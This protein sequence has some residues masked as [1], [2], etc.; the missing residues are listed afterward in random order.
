MGAVYLAQD[1]TLGRNVAIKVVST[2]IAGDAQSKLRFIREARTLA[3]IE[4]PHVV[5]V[6]EFGE[7]GG[8]AYLVME[9][10]EGETLA[11]RLAVGGPLP[12]YEALRIMRQVM[13]ALE[14]AWERRVIHRDIK[15][16][17]ILIDRRG[18][19]RVADFGLA[20]PLDLPEGD[21]SLTQ[22]GFLLGTPDYV[23]PEQAQGKEIDF[24]SDIYSA[25][26]ALYQMLVGSTPFEG[27]TQIAVISKHLQEPVPSIR[28]RRADVSYELEKLVMWMTAKEPGERPASH[29]KLM[30]A[31]DALLP[32]APISPP[33]SIPTVPLAGGARRPGLLGRDIQTMS[34]SARVALVAASSAL[35]IAIGWVST[36]LSARRRPPPLDVAHV[37]TRPLAVAVTPFYGPDEDS[38]KEGRVMASLI[39]DAIVQRLGEADARVF[40]I[41]ETKSPVRGHEQA[42][43]LAGRLDANAV[44]WGEAFAVRGETEIQPRVTIMRSEPSMNAARR[45]YEPFLPLDQ[46][47]SPTARFLAEAPNQIELRRTSAAGIADLVL[48]IAAAHALTTQGA[49]DRALDYL[50]QAPR[51]AENLRL[52]AQALAQLNRHDDAYA[53]VEE[54]IKLDRNSA[55]TYALLGDLYLAANRF[56]EAAGAYGKAEQ[57]GRPYTSN[58]GF[59]Q[60]G[61]LYLREIYRSARY[62][63]GTEQGTIYLLAVDPQT[64]HV[65][66]RYALPGPPLSFRRDGDSIEITYGLWSSVGDDWQEGQ[67]TVMFIK[68]EFDRPLW[69]PPWFRARIESKQSGYAIAANFIASLVSWRSWEDD[70][71]AKFELAGRVSEDVPS[72]LPDLETAL[73]AAADR[74]PTQPWYLFLLTLTLDAEGQKVDAHAMLDEMLRNDYP[75]TP[76]YEFT[77]MMAILERMR[78]YDWCDS[79]FPKAL[80][81]RSRIPQ[82][83]G[84]AGWG[85]SAWSAPFAREAAMNRDMD[86]AWIALDRAR[87][88]GG[89]RVDG[90]AQAAAAWKLYFMEHGDS[91][92]ADHEKLILNAMRDLPLS[93]AQIGT[94]VD[95]ALSLAIAS[96]FSFLSLAGVVVARAAAR[97]DR[98]SH[99]STSPPHLQVRSID[100]VASA[101]GVALAG[102]GGSAIVIGGVWLLVALWES[103]FNAVD[104]SAVSLLGA[105][106]VLRMLLR[107]R[108]RESRV[109]AV[110]ALLACV[111][112]STAYLFSLA[113]EWANVFRESP[114][115]IVVFLVIAG[116]FRGRPLSPTGI[117]S[118]L[119]PRERLAMALS[120]APFLASMIV[121]VLAFLHLETAGSVPIIGD[122]L[123]HETIVSDLE[124]RLARKPGSKP[125]VYVTAVANHLA[126]NRAR[127]ETLYAQLSDDPRAR[128]NAAALTKGSMPVNP[129]TPEDISRAYASTGGSHALARVFQDLP[130]IG[131]VLLGILSVAS[132]LLLMM[133]SLRSER[134]R[135]QMQWAP[136]TASMARKLLMMLIPGLYDAWQGAYWRTYL[137]VLLC[138]F[139]VLPAIWFLQNDFIPVTSG[140]SDLELSFPLPFTPEQPPL[141]YARFAFLEA[142]QYGRL[143]WSAV[144]LSLIVGLGM[145]LQRIPAILRLLREAPLAAAARS[146]E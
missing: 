22:G 144:A 62:T 70:D 141:Q 49:P 107:N 83:V 36:T 129:V 20:K 40:G 5:R 42:R 133:A 80:A 2:R 35:I 142:Y 50:R 53:A 45:A 105:S 140:M 110:G 128:A 32:A 84:V 31:L 114:Y 44:V 102:A 27:A 43:E 108:P 85:E 34:L 16:S 134:D 119:R 8:T 17:N 89:F 48:T 124:N 66:A 47:E 87:R 81:Q 75:G 28:A 71:V 26:I 91:M 94:Q 121:F 131:V 61:K 95:Y 24:R 19:V 96:L 127:A 12:V 30:A 63:S 54:A 82:P 136:A 6:Y 109:L 10:V 115:L 145:H 72:T 7:Q 143:F 97:A 13:E 90:D 101:Y 18:Q 103:S 125:V 25:G 113:L 4:H 33:P 79:I 57:T 39:E 46:E 11:D 67:R 3:T 139:P 86:R 100:G 137:I 60:R 41:E 52:Q 138:G 68:G 21:A 146:P 1:L 69:P 38:A 58:R 92:S 93:S 59:M 37:G 76:Y 99:S 126:G 15:P 78:R 65:T 135:V 111:A 112:V 64:R 77:A 122:S 106:P 132:V 123:G 74:D 55:D 23:S 117:L 29:Q 130:D 120:Y 51:T 56:D 98:R 88:I 73:R 9:W 104:L 118:A 116:I 14:A